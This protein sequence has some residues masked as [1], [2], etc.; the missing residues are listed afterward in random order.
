MTCKDGRFNTGNKV[1]SNDLRDLN[2]D[3]IIVDGYVNSQELYIEDRLGVERLTLAGIQHK[4]DKQHDDI[5]ERADA[6]NTAI[7]ER[8]DSTISKFEGEI[9]AII[10]DAGGVEVVGEFGDSIEG[11]I[12]QRYVSSMLLRSL[13]FKSLGVPGNGSD[14]SEMVNKLLSD[15]DSYD[16]VVLEDYAVYGLSDT[17]IIPKNKDIIS[18]GATFNKIFSGHEYA[19]LLEGNNSIDCLT[20]NLTSKLNSDRAVL[21]GGGS[22]NIGSLVVKSDN[23]SFTSSGTRALELLDACNV[24]INY[25]ETYKISVPVLA[26]NTDGLTILSGKSEKYRTGVY[27]RNS[28][29]I[30]VYN[31]DLSKTAQSCNGGPGEN[32]VLIE[33]T[34]TS[35]SYN[36]KFI[37]CSVKD[38]GEHAFRIGGSGIIKDVDFIRCVSEN[39]GNA[40]SIGNPNSTEWHGGCG[41]KILGGNTQNTNQNNTIRLIDCEVR[42][43]NSVV[44]TYPTGHNVNNFS[45][46]YVGIAYNV[47]VVRMTTV[48]KEGNYILKPFEIISSQ[49]VVF[50]NCT[51]EGLYSAG[52]F[53]AA[54]AEY[55]LGFSLNTSDIQ[56]KNCEFDFREAPSNIP[57]SF[58]V[59]YLNETLGRP[60]RDIQF[61][62]CTTYAKSTLLETVGDHVYEN[63]SYEGTYECEVDA[64]VTRGKNSGVSYNISTF[65]DPVMPLDV[66]DSVCR[67]INKGFERVRSDGYWRI[68]ISSKIIKLPPGEDFSLVI[69]NSNNINITLDG[70]NTFSYG[71]FKVRSGSSPQALAISNISSTL[72]AVASGQSVE[73]GKVNVLGTSTGF[74]I[75]NNTTTSQVFK[76]SG[77]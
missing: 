14:V 12:S 20:V 47:R 5:Q 70:I 9:D 65:S 74:T 36:I 54:D 76:I 40:I 62:Q 44:G 51:F 31:Y 52:T 4:S 18:N 45:A 49:N 28:R 55:N 32:G 10:K 57:S 24:F 39:S 2:D 27:L 16:I 13:N 41:F 73:S 21:A 11:V 48:S 46:V 35:S 43:V 59:G 19:V 3:V 42:G 77:F 34:D 26:T 17:L 30:R 72:N 61:K 50:D 22:I 68:N 60:F 75:S 25:I 29:N 1:C 8:A 38:S 53:L 58:L 69:G 6:Q 37:D 71:S 33:S 67:Y 56:F 63:I 15:T 23:D 66:A 7:T 64:V